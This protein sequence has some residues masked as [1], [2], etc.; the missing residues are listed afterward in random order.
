MNICVILNLIFYFISPHLLLQTIFQICG[1]YCIDNPLSKGHNPSS[2]MQICHS[3]N[4][5]PHGLNMLGT[6]LNRELYPDCQRASNE[7]IFLIVQWKG[8]NFLLARFDGDQT[9][10]LPSFHFISFTLFAPLISSI[11]SH[12]LKPIPCHAS[13]P[14]HLPFWNIRYLT[15]VLPFCFTLPPLP[16]HCILFPDRDQSG[17]LIAF[18]RLYVFGIGTKI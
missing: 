5:I 3:L 15:F 14:F 8:E 17:A 10:F 1:I 13:L 2:S 18:R 6:S 16:F 11:F 12:A 4:G 9:S 7:S